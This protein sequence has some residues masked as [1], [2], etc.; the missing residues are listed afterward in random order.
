MSELIKTNLYVATSPT[1]DEGQ[2]LTKTNLY[3]GLRE[4]TGEGFLA[5]SNLYVT[6]VLNPDT[7]SRIAKTNLYIN[8]TA[9]L[10]GQYLTWPKVDSS[11]TTQ[12]FLDKIELDAEGGG[13]F[14]SR[15]MERNPY[16]AHLGTNQA[17]LQED[18]HEQQR[19]LREQHNKTQAGD[20]TFDYGLLLKSYPNQEFTLGSLGRFFH[21]DFGIII[22]RFVQFMG[23][24][25]D[26]WQG[27]PV[28]RLKNKDSFVDWVVTNDFDKSDPDL[29]LGFNFASEPPADGTYGWMVVHG[30]N[31]ASI[32]VTTTNLPSQNAQYT[33]TQTGGVGLDES[34][35][36]LGRRW[37]S[38]DHVGLPAGSLFIRIEGRGDAD[39]EAFVRERLAEDLE[40]L[41]NI[42]VAVEDLQSWRAT[43]V[44][45][46]FEELDKTDE[47]L[48]FRIHR[49]EIVRGREIQALRGQLELIVPDV[50]IV[51]TRA[52]LV[53]M[54]NEGDANVMVTANQALLLS[55][56]LENTI[57]NL[58][59]TDYDGLA[60]L[61]AVVASIDAKFGGLRFDTETTPLADGQVFIT[62]HTTNPD[63][64]DT[65]TLGAIEYKLSSLLD[66][67][68][69]AISDGQGIKWS[70]GK[71]IATDFPSGGGGG[72]GAAY[73][74]HFPAGNFAANDSGSFATLSNA[75]I[76][77]EDIK[78]NRLYAGFNN[79]TIGNEY[80]MF[81]AEIDSSGVIQSTIATAT[82]RFTTVATGF[83]FQEFDIPE[84]TLNRGSMYIIALVITSGTGTTACRIMTGGDYAY[85]ALP[86][87]YGAMAATWGSNRRRFWYSQNS[88]AP[89]S[90]SPSGN[91]TTTPYLIGLRKVEEASSG[92]GGDASWQDLTFSN[93]SSAMWGGSQ[94]F[95]SDQSFATQLGDKIEIEWMGLRTGGTEFNVCLSGDGNSCILAALQT[96]NNRV[97]YRYSTVGG[98]STAI[99][100]DPGNT[101][102]QMTRGLLSIFVGDSTYMH[103]AQM[104]VNGPSGVP[105]GGT[106]PTSILLDGQS[107]TKVYVQ[108]NGSLANLLWARVRI[109]RADGS[110]YP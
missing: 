7:V 105:I 58:D 13:K 41:E 28:G 19:I 83:Q 10:F 110:T 69:S 53:N 80:S 5:K 32:R 43:V 27:Q 65:Y 89:T 1:V 34:G 11:T 22:A 45:P 29:V 9:D 50:S 75:I 17:E 94:T 64:N 42:R 57:N 87:D 60:G 96:D 38:S 59:F 109:L 3:V 44:T 4:Y 108:P 20:T 103:S 40:L 18:F 14:V 12:T 23:M 100:A 61:P 47:D 99:N 84:T 8:Q 36:V 107:A 91:A 25:E 52:E 78:V 2:C 102:T 71:F 70:G 76:P 98:G 16:R 26:D 6:E 48:Y 68:V 15:D 101:G 51:A 73:S 62:S 74:L 63:G 77:G 21:D 97:L 92:G 37:A 106:V 86:I 67:D 93:S 79:A 104:D 35:I 81:I 72:S 30:A 66:V 56:S 85:P 33:W 24:L 39:L 54:I 88:D 95:E 82:S 46:K 31:P 90:G 55:Q 49:E